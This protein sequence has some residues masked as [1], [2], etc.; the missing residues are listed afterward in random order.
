MSLGLLLMLCSLPLFPVA[1]LLVLFLCA[2]SAG[3]SSALFLLAV[4]VGGGV[5][6]LALVLS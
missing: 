4:P 6:F 1:V 2:V 3:A 5:S